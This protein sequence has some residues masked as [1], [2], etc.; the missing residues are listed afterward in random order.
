MSNEKPILEIDSNGTKRWYLND[1][2][3]REDGPVHNLVDDDK[4]WYLYGK[5][6]RE[7]GPAAEYVNGNKRWFLNGKRHREDGPA[8]EYADGEKRWYLHDENVTEK[9]EKL[10]KEGLTEIEALSFLLL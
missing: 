9:V 6:H 1:E 10:M 8:I 5:F 2:L 7:D 3:H 4:F